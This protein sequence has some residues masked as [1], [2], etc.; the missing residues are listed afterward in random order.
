ML[1]LRSGRIAVDVDPRGAAITRFVWRRADGV[2]IPMLREAGGYDGN[3]LH[4]SCFPLI[5]F[6]N[7]VRDNRF[8]CDG[9]DYAFKPN[10]SWDRHYLHGDGWLTRW[11][12]GDA[13][14]LTMGREADATSPYAYTAAI[15]FTVTEAA[16][17]V[18]MSVRNEGER[19]LPFGLGLHPYFPLTPETTLR[20][21]ASSFF[22]EEA[23]FMPGDR[24]AVPGTLDFTHAKMPPRH[25]TNNGFSGWDGR[26]DIAWPERSAALRI[27]ADP[28]FRDYFVFMSDR[29]FEPDFA[30]DYFCFEP[31][32]HHADA[33]HAP[34]LGGL[35]V[36]A[37]GQ[38]LAAGISFVPHDI[39]QPHGTAP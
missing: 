10:Q 37:P 11:R 35:A 14:T 7:R 28:S 8:A 9:H 1:K 24:T 29:K 3:P 38:T 18:A 15:E 20:A 36:L 34:D 5:P 32:T 26:A 17:R 31:M 39:S 4:A 25:W 30:G 13:T 33:H 2:E 21:P 16:L 27:E 6:G 23:E 12:D 19:V 22:T